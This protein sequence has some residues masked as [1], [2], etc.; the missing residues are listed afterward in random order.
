MLNSIIRSLGRW[1]YRHS[2]PESKVRPLELNEPNLF[3]AKTIMFTVH[4]AHGGTVI[5][6]NHYDHKTDSNIKQ[7]HVITDDLDL[8]KE[9]GHLITL[10]RL[11]Q[12]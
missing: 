2:S 4:F 10:A 9:M 7:L 1:C 8:G 12:N 3:S 11:Q 6:T 5:E